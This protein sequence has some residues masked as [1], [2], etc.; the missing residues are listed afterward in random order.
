MKIKVMTHILVVCE[1]CGTEDE[2][3]VNCQRVITDQHGWE[4]DDITGCYCQTCKE[5]AR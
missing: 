5:L 3:P 1:T 2:L 4:L